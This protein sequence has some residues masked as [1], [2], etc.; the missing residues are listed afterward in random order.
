MAESFIGEAQAALGRLELAWFADAP[1]PSSPA[2]GAAADDA[3]EQTVGI[4]APQLS[5]PSV[6]SNDLP[7]PDVPVG[8]LLQQSAAARGYGRDA[9]QG[10]LDVADDDQDEDRW[11]K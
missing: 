9:E 7:M 10:D 3:A 4:G 11:M 2:G 6:P 8:G 5:S 1:P